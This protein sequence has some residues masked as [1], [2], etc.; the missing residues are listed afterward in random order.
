MER[1]QKILSKAGVASRREAEKLIIAGRVTVNGTVAKL[2]DQAEESDTIAVDGTVIGK[3]EEK[4]YFLLNKPRGYL[5]T[6][7]DD[8]GRRTVLE[9]L[10]DIKEYI[11]PVGRLDYNTTGLLLLTN[12]GEF[13]NGLLHPSR[14]VHKTYAAKVKGIPD[15]GKLK[16]LRQGVMLEDGITAPAE[17]RLIERGTKET[18]D[19][20]FLDWSTVQLTIHEGRNRQVRRMMSAVGHDVL[21]LKRTAFAG[22][23]LQG[24]GVGKY[25]E[26]TKEEVTRLR[27]LYE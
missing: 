25:R 26:L 8:R 24:V 14:E 5:C 13:M 2:G 1:L 22:L 4:L 27:S 11:Y 18:E 7:K 17:V 9:L 21:A 20:R 19:G 23:N 10:S 12:D 6:V 3:A 15:N 16:T